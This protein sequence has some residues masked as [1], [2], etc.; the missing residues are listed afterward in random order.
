MQQGSRV[1]RSDRGG[2][3]G[4]GGGGGSLS[5]GAAKGLLHQ[6]HS[7]RLS[8]D[9]ILETTPRESRYSNNLVELMKREEVALAGGGGAATAKSLKELV[10]KVDELL[11]A[12]TKAFFAKSTQHNIKRWK[13]LAD[14]LDNERMRIRAESNFVSEGGGDGNS[15]SKWRGVNSATG[16]GSSPSHKIDLDLESRRLEEDYSRNW[17]KYEDFHLKEAFKVVMMFIFKFVLSIIIYG[18]YFL[19][20]LLLI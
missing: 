5:S 16:G 1:T 14:K 9:L 13:S 2:G 20:C 6:L 12:E 15:S 7:Q 3:G 18:D 17:G 8:M 4:G 19:L 10:A 11:Y